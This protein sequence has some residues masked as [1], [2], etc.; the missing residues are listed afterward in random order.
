MSEQDLDCT[1]CPTTDRT[2]KDCDVC[3]TRDALSAKQPAEPERPVDIIRRQNPGAFI[4]TGAELAQI[5]K[6]GKE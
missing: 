3:L 6:N 1:S 5:L 2:A 4:P